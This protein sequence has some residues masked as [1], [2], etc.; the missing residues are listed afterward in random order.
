MNCEVRSDEHSGA[1]ASAV[2][3]LRHS[4]RDVEAS[5]LTTA[6]EILDCVSANAPEKTAR[7]EFRLMVHD[8]GGGVQTL[9]ANLAWKRDDKKL[10]KVVVRLSVPADLRGLSYLL[11]EREKQTDMFAYFPALKLVR[12][13]TGRHSAGSDFSF[14]DVQRLHNVAVKGQWIRLADEEVAGRVSYVIE[15]QAAPAEEPAYDKTLSYV[16][17]ASCVAIKTVF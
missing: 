3:C 8:R 16:D 13:V 17:Q 11:I 14:E 2:G 15:T 12:R 9:Q 10:S 6:N 4:A 1:L 5:G 7:Q